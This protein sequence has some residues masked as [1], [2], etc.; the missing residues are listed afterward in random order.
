MYLKKLPLAIILLLFL[1][2]SVQGQSSSTFK[3]GFTF[4]PQT[5]FMPNEG[6]MNDPD[7]D[8]SWRTGLMFGVDAGFEF[9]DVSLEF[10]IYQSTQGVDFGNPTP[11]SA[12]VEL[13]YLK[14]P[15][16]LSFH[17]LK[18]P[19][20]PLVLRGGLQVSSLLNATI[21]MPSGWYLPGEDTQWFN[22][23]TVDLVGGI[24]LDIPLLPRLYFN[25]KIRGDWSLTDPEKKEHVY[26]SGGSS[27]SHWETG[28]SSTSNVTIGLSLGIEYHFNKQ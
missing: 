2:G 12:P 17:P 27:G 26:R 25:P 5:T 3:L 10:G 28:R 16:T 11:Y 1:I 18:N 6:E 20:F 13:V 9:E 21:D 24:G 4:M 23:H 7:L 22:K 14:T 15:V 19:D 8:P